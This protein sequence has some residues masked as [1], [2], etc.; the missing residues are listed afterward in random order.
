M[1]ISPERRAQHRLWLFEITQIPTAAGREDRVIR[2][3][4]RW[5]QQR[6]GVLLTR[7]AGGNLVLSLDSPASHAPAPSV[8]FTAHL[9]H[10]A[11]V[12]E[13]VVSPTTLEMSFRGGVM[14]DYFASA[15]VNVFNDRDEAHAG[16]VRGK[17]GS[18]AFGNIWTIELD[19]PTS[20]IVPADVGRWLLPPAQE[21]DGC[22]HTDACDDLSAVAAALSALDELRLARTA[23]T[24]EVH[25][26]VRVLFTRAEEIGFIGAIAACREATIPAGTRVIAL[27]NSR[28]FPDSPIHA[29]PIVR[30]GDRVSVFSPSLTGAIAKRAEE[31]GGPSTV[32]ASQKLTPK[33]ENA[34]RWQRKLMAG[35]ACEAS[36]FCAFGHEA[37]CVCLALGNYHNMGDLAGVQAG[38]NTS[39]ATPAR[40]FVGLR[41]YDHLVELLVACGERLEG[42]GNVMGMVDRL[43]GEK[44][45]V[46]DS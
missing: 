25:Q 16:T 35:G 6:K 14:D 21:I 17:N 10:P 43:W 39:P 45:S 42:S 36:V 19:L 29:G 27:E 11:F 7:D 9:D 38:T 24:G 23:G 34:F 5:C 40:E 31:L 32:T 22:I 33:D 2:W 13:R 26:D 8:W 3:I 1:P 18:N 41:D 12:V 28:S 4:E 44:A 15:R 20:T 37:T 30:V 46:L